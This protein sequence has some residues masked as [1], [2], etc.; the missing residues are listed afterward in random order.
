MIRTGSDSP[1]GNPKTRWGMAGLRK[2]PT[3]PV[4][5]P[6]DAPARRLLESAVRFFGFM[7]TPYLLCMKASA[8]HSRG[9]KIG[10]LGF[11]PAIRDIAPPAERPHD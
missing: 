1:V 3:A 8:G 11:P 10:R 5:P 7:A 9:K 4:A 6:G 2:A